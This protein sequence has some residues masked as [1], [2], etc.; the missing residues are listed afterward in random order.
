MD[1]HCPFY[2]GSV[3]DTLMYVALEGPVV[4]VE[5]VGLDPWGQY[6]ILAHMVRIWRDLQSNAKSMH[7]EPGQ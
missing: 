5:K 2:E 3:F 4:L 7:L 1:P 6:S